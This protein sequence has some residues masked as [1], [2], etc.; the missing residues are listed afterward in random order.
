MKNLK[1]KDL[2]NQT[3]EELEAMVLAEQAAM[4]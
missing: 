4:Y 3:V 1:A 2:R